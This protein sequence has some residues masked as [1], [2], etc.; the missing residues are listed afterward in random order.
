M[1][2][3]SISWT[4]LQR[5][6]IIVQIAYILP[7]NREELNIKHILSYKKKVNENPLDYRQLKGLLRG[8]WL[9][10]FQLRGWK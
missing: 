5:P 7:V 6:E 2:V 1:F 10:N 9:L 3:T 4:K 8:N